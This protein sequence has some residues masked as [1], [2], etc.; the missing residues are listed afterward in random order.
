MY[1]MF[2]TCYLDN[3]KNF[4]LK[5]FQEMLNYKD[6][7]R[8]EENKKQNRIEHLERFSEIILILR[9]HYSF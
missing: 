2:L 3:L 6:K 1:I 8:D 7:M 4:F 9:K 5:S